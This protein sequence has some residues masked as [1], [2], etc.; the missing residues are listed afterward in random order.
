MVLNIS[1]LKSGH[2]DFVARDIA[3]VVQVAQRYGAPVKVILECYL[4]TDEEKVVASQ[5]AEREGA[6]FIKTSTQTQ[7]GGA[8]VEDVRLIRATVGPAVQVKASGYITDIDKI[9]A[10]YEAGARRFG[11]GFTA[12]ILE[13]LKAK[14]AA[15]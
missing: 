13:G 2:H 14:W 6:A 7:P 10:L 5:I 4:L 15:L 11:T 3:G 8:T 9:L 12:Q 1:E